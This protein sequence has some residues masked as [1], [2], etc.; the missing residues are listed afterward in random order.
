MEEK[1]G[2]VRVHNMENDPPVSDR[3]VNSA[4]QSWMPT[5]RSD[6]SHYSNEKILVRTLKNFDGLTSKKV[7]TR[8]GSALKEFKLA[9]DGYRVATVH[10]LSLSTHPRRFAKPTRP[11]DRR[12]FHSIWH[13]PSDGSRTI[14]P[15]QGHF[16]SVLRPSERRS[17]DETHFGNEETREFVE[18]SS[19][20]V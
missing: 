8:G 6:H 19:A 13:A 1:K 5:I 10:A 17:S 14:Q 7:Q 18:I 11:Q 2:K 15:K 12:N 3:G 16:D 4:K 9:S 20:L